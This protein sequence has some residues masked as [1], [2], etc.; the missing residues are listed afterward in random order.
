MERDGF[1][2]FVVSPKLQWDASIPIAAARAGAVGFLDLTYLGDVSAAAGPLDRLMRLSGGS[3]GV[4]LA[5]RQNDVAESVL[6]SLEGAAETSDISIL[7]NFECEEELDPVLA[8]ARRKARRVGVVVTS[9]A[10]ALI[11]ARH[12]VDLLV[13]KGWE[14][15]GRIG[16]QT[17]FALVQRLLA[18]CSLPVYAWGGAGWHTTAAYRV[19]GAAGV[20]LDWQLALMAES[21]LPQIFRCQLAGGPESQQP[22]APSTVI[23]APDGRRLRVCLPPGTPSPC[24]VEE[25]T[26]KADEEGV[27]DPSASDDTLAALMAPSDVL[28]PLWLLGQDAVGAASGQPGRQTCR[29]R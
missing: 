22:G 11:A 28:W 20:V 18:S 6:K 9:E 23:R 19:A 27:S 1:E 21:P 25:L 3:I 24:E 26:E 12:R 8:A 5:G 15:G 13:A 17:A 2:Y 4:V 16:E 7:L 10:E 14:T 29:G